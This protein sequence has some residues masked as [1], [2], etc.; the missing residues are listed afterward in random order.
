MNTPVRV[1]IQPAVYLLK[2]ARDTLRRFKQALT[3][4]ILA[5][6][7]KQQPY[8]GHYLLSVYH[9]NTFLSNIRCAG[10]GIRADGR[11]RFRAAVLREPQ[12]MAK[13]KSHIVKA[14]HAPS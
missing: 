2:H 13:T 11:T 3:P 12:N 14:K 9:W 4:D 5:N 7:F 10:V 6:P 8:P 1:F